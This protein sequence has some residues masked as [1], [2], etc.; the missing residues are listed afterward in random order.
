MFQW[1]DNHQ[2]RGRFFLQHQTESSDEII[3]SLEWASDTRVHD[4]RP[5]LHTVACAQRL[6]VRSIEHLGLHAAR[7]ERYAVLRDVLTQEKVTQLFRDSDEMVRKRY[8]E[9]VEKPGEAPGEEGGLEKIIRRKFVRHEAHSVVEQ[10]APGQKF[11]HVPDEQ[12][13]I[14]VGMNNRNSLSPNH[15]AKQHEQKDVQ[16]KFFKGWAS[17]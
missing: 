4:Y 13:F 2:Q 3:N 11:G 9:P 5:S 15:A 17:V 14:V 1:A 8:C 7:N 12:T 10:P 16:D 6:G